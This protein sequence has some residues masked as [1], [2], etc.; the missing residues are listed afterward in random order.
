MDRQLTEADFRQF[1]VKAAGW[2]LNI[3]TAGSGPPA[4]FMPGLGVSWQWWLSTM[5]HAAHGR[6]L[7]TVDL[8]GTGRASPL[9]RFPSA[10]RIADA[11]ADLVQ[12]MDLQDA[13][14]VGHSLGGFL[15]LQHMARGGSGI[16]RALV[17]APGG[18]APM[19]SS[20]PYMAVFGMIGI[21][22]FLRR[23][24]RRLML[25]A[26]AQWMPVDA[27]VE[28]LATHDT[29]RT[30]N[31]ISLAYQLF[32][33]TRLPLLKEL[34]PEGAPH[35]KD[36]VHIIWGQNDSV[37]RAACAPALAKFLGGA[38]VTAYDD[39]DH[40]PHFSEKER[41]RAQLRQWLAQR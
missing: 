1:K 6:T 27:E 12:H 20:K 11:M 36:R 26:Y 19:L 28:A 17:L 4:L 35:L 9:L 29:R 41:F 8:P 18:V 30:A 10:Q 24:Y 39:S 16:R 2:T 34:F 25:S 3:A 38:E 37:F 15:L 33:S 31:R 5:Q 32:N 23:L 21:V 22:P 13:D 14:A 7:F 40:F